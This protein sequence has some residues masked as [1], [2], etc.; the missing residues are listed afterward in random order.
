MTP[1]LRSRLAVAL[2]ALRG[3]AVAPAAP[4]VPVLPPS[5]TP[6]VAP[7]LDALR[8]AAAARLEA[9]SAAQAAARAEVTALDAMAASRSAG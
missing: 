2:A 4:A 8:R 7:D 9:A 1:D 6:A 3:R 5:P